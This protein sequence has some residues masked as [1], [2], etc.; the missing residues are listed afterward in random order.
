MGYYMRFIVTDE[1]KVSLTE[2]ESALKEIDKNYQI[3]RD[4]GDETEG[5]LIYGDETYGQLFI[6]ERDNELFE[7]EIKEL[8][9]FLKDAE[10]ENK[11]KVLEVLKNAKAIFCIRVLDQSREVE[12]TLIKIDPFWKWF[13]G[14]RKGLMQAE[15]EG[16]YDASGLILEFK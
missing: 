3:D 7:E 2:L 8:I 5:I 13:F 16:Y 11:P 4:E 9:E 12:E 1:K 14:N 10:G 15:L 6:S